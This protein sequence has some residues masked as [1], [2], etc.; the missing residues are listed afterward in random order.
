MLEIYAD[1][2]KCNHGS[3]VGKLDEN[4]LF[5]MRQRGIPEQEARLLLQH[6][7]INDVLQTRHARTFAGT[8]IPF[9]LNSVFAE[10]CVIATGCKMQDI[11]N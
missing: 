2:V 4:A 3:T 11:C 7:F 1:D 10:S 6:A 9:G 5:Y 8:P